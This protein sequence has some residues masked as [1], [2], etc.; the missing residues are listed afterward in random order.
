MKIGHSSTDKI[1]KVDCDERKIA[2]SRREDNQE[3]ENHELE[4]LHSAQGDPDQSLGR[5]EESPPQE[6]SSNQGENS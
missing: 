5:V 3:L 1:V 2:L 6:E 4:E